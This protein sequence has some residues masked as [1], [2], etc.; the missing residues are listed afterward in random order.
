MAALEFIAAVRF[1]LYSNILFFLAR[2]I[3][4]VWWE[5]ALDFSKELSPPFPPYPNLTFMGD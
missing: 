3:G 5:Q 2:L 4:L 1:H